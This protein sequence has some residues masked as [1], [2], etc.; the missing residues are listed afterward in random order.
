MNIK[1]GHF[2]NF[3]AFFIVAVVVALW[4]FPEVIK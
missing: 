1:E 3:F 4:Y 2:W